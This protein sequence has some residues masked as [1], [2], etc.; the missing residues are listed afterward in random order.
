MKYP[1]SMQLRRHTLTV[2]SWILAVVAALSVTLANA[3]SPECAF[4]VTTNGFTVVPNG[5]P[6]TPGTF[7]LLGS[8]DVNLR[9]GGRD[10]YLNGAFLSRVFGWPNGFST[11]SLPLGLHTL[12]AQHPADLGGTCAGQFTETTFRLTNDVTPPVIS[13]L[14]INGIGVGTPVVLT[15]YLSNRIEVTVTDNSA[16]AAQILVRARIGTGDWFE[17]YSNAASIPDQWLRSIWEGDFRRV[18][19]GP[20][21]FTIEAIDNSGNR[22]E[23]SRPIEISLPPPPPPSGGFHESGISDT[24]SVPLYMFADPYVDRMRIV[25]LDGLPEQVIDVYMYIYDR[26][27]VPAD[28]T[29]RFQFSSISG[30][31]ESELTPP[32]TI[33]VDRQGP[34]ASDWRFDGT[35]SL[36]GGSTI[37]RRGVLS[38]RLNDPSGVV[39]ESI[40]LKVGGVTIS[41]GVWSPFGSQYTVDVDFDAMTDGPKIIE[42]TATDGINTT[43]TNTLSINVAIAPLDAPLLELSSPVLTRSPN[44]GVTGEAREYSTVS[45]LLNGVEVPPPLQTTNARYF[46]RAVTLP[47]EGIYEIRASASTSR[48][49]SPL[50]APRTVTYDATSPVIVSIEF[51]GSPL[52]SGRVLTDVGRL[53]IVATDMVGLDSLQATSV[54]VV[55]AFG[56]NGVIDVPLDFAAVANGDYSLTITARDQAGNVTEQTLSFRVELP[57]PSVAPVITAPLDGV[58][59]PASDVIVQGSAPLGTSVQLYLNGAA[60]GSLLSV[61]AQGNFVGSVSALVEGNNVITARSVNPRGSSPESVPVNR[62]VDRTPP[63]IDTIDYAGSTLADGR[64]LTTTGNLRV[65]ASDVKG[66]AS[67][68]V[69]IPGQYWNRVNAAVFDL[70]LSFASTVNGAYSLTI[71][72]VD[73]VGN[74]SERTISFTLTLPPP[75]SPPVILFPTSGTQ[76]SQRSTA[77]SGTATPDTQVQLYVN[78]VAVPGLVGV[79]ANGSFAS[80]VTNL[81]EGSSVFSAE[82]RNIRGAS[83]RSAPVSVTFTASPPTLVFSSPGNGATVTADTLIELVASANAP[84]SIASVVLSIDGTAVATLSNAPYRFNWDVSSIANG[85]HTL[86]AVATDSS[87]ASTTTTISI[88]LNKPPPPVI[89][90]YIGRV[91]GVSPAASFGTTPVVVQGRALGRFDSAPVGGAPLLLRLNN[92]GFVRTVNVVTGANG[93]FS[94]NFVPQSTDSGAYQVSLIH[95]DEN[96]PPVVQ[97]NFSVERLSVNNSRI[98]LRAARGFP[99][100][101]TVYLSSSQGS[102]ATNVSLATPAAAQPSGSVPLGIAASAV[103]VTVSS[104]SGQTAYEITFTSTAQSPATGV[105]VAQLFATESGSVARA[106]IRIDYE[107]VTAEPVLVPTP[108]LL[109]LGAKRGQPISDRIVIDNNGLVAANGVTAT[110]LTQENTTPPAWLFLTSATNL[111]D[112]AAGGKRDVQIS[113]AP[114]VGVNDGIYQF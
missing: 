29:Y 38:V 1:L 108:S 99:E 76:L 90:P 109:S 78:D 17:L 27:D 35:M 18:N 79:S 6:V 61:N 59:T 97:G 19:N 48:Q 37:T 68:T 102:T 8:T 54:G 69:S 56:V 3:Q 94:F 63:T 80:F 33:I 77:I 50:S 100:R 53:R 16:S 106:E 84:R 67:I 41:G 13:G 4:E 105:L 34:A 72:A 32:K 7:L 87:G 30:D 52:V 75:S 24:L 21:Q 93:A 44:M 101:F 46:S 42:L 114:D 64:V 43:A 110:L 74:T 45:L 83:P 12:R 22:S 86:S 104:A 31:R 82:S 9:N 47:S 36:T 112:I 20:T 92:N 5:G 11:S 113:A 70:P 66:V 14:T 15:S 40:V 26:I 39:P 58:T 2:F 95:P 71:T 88:T 89:T 49:T 96:T 111:G 103:P 98:R 91:D 23:F 107:L 62:Y 60:V 10:L 25:S 57:P 81:A 55:N 85:A 65:V 73:T 51:G 28:G